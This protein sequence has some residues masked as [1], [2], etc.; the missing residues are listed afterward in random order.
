MRRQD[1]EL[2]IDN[3]E[4][5]N[6][7]RERLVNM[8]LAQFEWNGLPETCDRLYFEKTLLF[9]GTACMC[10]PTGTDIWL[11]VGYLPMGTFDV[12]GYPT[13]V[14]GI[15][16]N[17][18]NIET[19][20]WMVLYDNMTLTTLMPKIDLYAKL[21]WECHNTFRSNLRQ[22]NTPYIV[23][24]TKNES[25][26]FKNIFNHIF[27][28]DPV[29]QVKNNI[30]LENSVKVL[31]LKKEYIGP[32]LLD[33]LKFIWNEALAMLGITGET[34]KKERMITDE[35]VLNRQEDCI[36]MSA[37]L[38][39]RVVF[40]NKMNERYGL[41]LSVNLVSQDTQFS[42]FPDSEIG[43]GEGKGEDDRWPSTQSQ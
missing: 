41:N 16:F 7:Y 9:N 42:P 40:C 8:A 19:E 21:L 15:G 35:L 22:Q 30:D 20:E 11:S 13:K 27:G 37:R 34:T 18:K 23:A 32:Q 17:A 1:R 26:S 33:S 14:R 2:V 28:F 39:N 3:V 24:T 5:Y 43:D 4:I 29:I 31:D 36:A 6:Y 25:L 38:L 10:K 12:Y